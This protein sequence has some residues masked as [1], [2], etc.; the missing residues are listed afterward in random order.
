MSFTIKPAYCQLASSIPTQAHHVFTG[1]RDLHAAP[2]QLW[3]FLRIS[4][5]AIRPQVAKVGR[6]TRRRRI[7]QR[8][9]KRVAA[10]HPLVKRVDVRLA[11]RAPDGSSPSKIDN[12]N[13]VV[14][15]LWHRQWLQDDCHGEGRS[16]K[17]VGGGGNVVEAATHEAWG[18]VAR[19]ANHKAGRGRGGECVVP[20]HPRLK[21]VDGCGVEVIFSVVWYLLC[22]LQCRGMCK[23]TR[24]CEIWKNKVTP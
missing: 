4:P 9:L 19:I 13:A 15:R 21:H 2:A 18:A 16:A 22:L 20:S 24:K 6:R 1:S 14:A 8:A 10:L 3:P 17:H 7:A 23:C 11:P 12:R 5:A